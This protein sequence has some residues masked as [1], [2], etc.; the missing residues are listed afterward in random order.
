MA[1]R[2]ALVV[3]VGFTLAGCGGSTSVDPIADP[4]PASTAD[5]AVG[6]DVVHPRWQPHH[7]AEDD[8]TLTI[9][10]FVPCGARYENFTTT[11]ESRSNDVIITVNAAV[12]IE[13]TGCEAGDAPVELELVLDEPLAGRTLVDQANGTG[14]LDWVIPPGSVQASPVIIAEPGALAEG[15]GDDGYLSLEF[16][17]MRVPISLAQIRAGGEVPFGVVVERGKQYSVAMGFVP[18]LP[19]APED[20]VGRVQVPLPTPL[21]GPAEQRLEI[22]LESGAVTA[23]ATSPTVDAERVRPTW[24]QVQ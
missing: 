22:L 11:A 24:Q 1:L 4:V 15:L 10:A 17:E 23:G 2:F 8:R 20:V 7:I 14:L 9:E 21:P 6:S 18:R 5:D 16:G 13:P 12:Q 3:V 19:M